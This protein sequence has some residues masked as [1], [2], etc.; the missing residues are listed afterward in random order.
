VY[1]LALYSGIKPHGNVSV[2]LSINPKDSGEFDL[3][4]NFKSYPL[5][6]SIPTVKPIPRIPFDRGS[7][8]LNGDWSV[9]HGIIKSENHLV[10]IDPRLNRP[11]EG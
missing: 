6:L 11:G 7:V 2:N 9:R 3:I 8:E 10:I 4:S 1:K 5:P